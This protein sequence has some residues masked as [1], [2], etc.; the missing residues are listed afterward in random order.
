MKIWVCVDSAR[1]IVATN[2]NDM[3]GNTGWEETTVAKL[4]INHGDNLSDAN[5]VALYALADGKAVVR[6]DEEREAD[7]TPQ[8]VKPSMSQRLDT[9]EAQ[10]EMLTECVLEM[11]GVVYA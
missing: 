8:E 4:G 10:N 2:L 9:L 7:Y 1:R 6:S 3:S 5:D 11:S